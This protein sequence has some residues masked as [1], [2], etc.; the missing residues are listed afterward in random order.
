MESKND[1]NIEL[2][3]SEKTFNP[4][5]LKINIPDLNSSPD[6]DKIIEELK[7]GVKN[8]M[9]SKQY[10]QF[11][12][13]MGNI[14][15]YSINNLF[16]IASQ[17]PESSLVGSF[18][19]WKKNNRFV[20]RGEKGIKI[21]AP[22]TKTKNIKV[23]DLDKSGKEILKS[24]GTKQFH[25]EK[26]TY[27]SGFRLAS[28]FDISQTGGEPIPSLL[29]E[30]SGDSSVAQ[31]LID[32]I[33]DISPIPIEFKEMESPNG[34]YLPKEKAIVIKDDMSTDQTAKTLIHEL[35]H[36]E[37]HND[38]KDYAINRDAYEIE[39]EST[40][41]VVS[42]HFGLDTSSYSFGYITSWAEGKSLEEYQKSLNTVSETAKNIII[43]IEN[44]LEKEYQKNLVLDKEVIKKNILA[45]GFK[46][47]SNVLKNM[48][49]LNKLTGKQLSIKEIKNLQDSNALENN[50]KGKKLLEDICNE[51]KNQELE[52]KKQVIVE[53]EII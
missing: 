7:K 1:K 40:A 5:D 16:L 47:T 26:R 49:A 35:T 36:S 17:K 31:K 37:L 25:I 27:I 19:F 39:A 53:P 18:S 8:L 38:I 14:Y 50:S 10:K 43:K 42:K 23:Y 24:D 48:I 13:F 22:N 46:P 51:F 28:V 29:N 33:K 4:K 11:L 34:Y 15:D 30:L 9:S 20:K 41:Y 44:Y 21:I 52:L 32:T 45:A 12:D 6:T 2:A 3:N